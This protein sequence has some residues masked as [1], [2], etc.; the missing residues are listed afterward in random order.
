MMNK[1]IRS[2][3]K[4]VDSFLSSRLIGTTIGMYPVM[5]GFLGMRRLKKSSSKKARD[6]YREHALHLSGLNLSAK[7]LAVQ[8]SSILNTIQKNKRIADE[9]DAIDLPHTLKLQNFHEKDTAFA[10]T[11][12]ELS[13][14]IEST[15]GVRISII[16]SLLWRNNHTDDPSL[17]SGDWHFDRRP[18]N[19][20]RLFIIASDDVDSDRGPFTFLGRIQSRKIVREGFR[21]EKTNVSNFQGIESTEFVGSQGASVIINT[22]YLLHRAGNPEWTKS[23]DMIQ[24]VFKV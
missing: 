1:L 13:R 4:R 17:F 24:I 2:H 11:L 18:T 23:R 22:Q 10:K 6:L 15:L 19:W 3:L 7:E 14:D 8:A 12:H 21:R 5:R 9:L 16:S 20:L